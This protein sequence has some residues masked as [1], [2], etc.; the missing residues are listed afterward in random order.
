MKNSRALGV[1]AAFLLLTVS[2]SVSCA[3]KLPPIP[4]DISSAEIIQKAQERSDLYDWKGAQYYYKA[5]L[6]K[7]PNDQALVVSA[8][9]ELAFIE[10]KQGHYD[11]A[12]VGLTAVLDKYATTEGASLPATW[13]ILAEKVMAKLPAAPSAA[14]NT[15]AGAVVAGT[16][17][18]T[19][20]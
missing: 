7:F 10:Y 9:Y 5:L 8:M 18:A 16:P 2:L 13:K 14:A 20:K 1:L 11:A 15:T 12:R 17:A 4:E 19:T 6:E 3:T